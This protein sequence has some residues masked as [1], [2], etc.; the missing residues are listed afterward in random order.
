MP[1]TR[2]LTCAVVTVCLLGL[3]VAAGTASGAEKLRDKSTQPNIVFILADDLGWTDLGCYGNQFIETPVIDALAAAGARFTSAYTA[4]VCTPSRGMILS[5][6]SSARTGLYK[7]PFRGNERP[8]AKVVP[9]KPWGDRPVNA[10]PIAALLSSAG[11]SSRLVG[12]VHVPPAFTEGF[13]GKASLEEATVA[14]GTTFMGKLQVFAKDN[15]EKNVGPITLQAIEFIASN[16]DRPFFCYVGHH[17]PHIPLEARALLKKKYETKWKNHGG[18]IHPHYAAM[19][20]ALDQSV[21]FVLE[22][23]DRLG[24]SDNT[25]VVF[26]SDNGGVKR[27]FDDGK[28]AQITDL[29]PLRGEKG[30]LYEGGIRVP[31]IVRWPGSIR[32]GLVIDTPVISTDF[33]PTL[34]EAAGASLPPEQ[35]VDGVS[36]VPLLKESGHLKRRRLFLYFPDYHHDFP[37][38]VM[39]DGNLKLIKSS[40][41][42]RL[43]IYDLTGD[44]EERRDLAMAMPLL[45]TT[46][47]RK[48]LDEWCTRLGAHRATPNPDFDPRR[49]HML[50]PEA[51]AIRQRYLP[52]PWPPVGNDA[53]A[54]VHPREYEHALKNPLKGFRSRQRV[55]AH[56]YATLCR[57][58]LKWSDLERNEADGIERIMAICNREWRDVEKHNIKVIPRVYLHWSGNR[59]YWPDDMDKDDYSSKQFRERVRRLISRLGQCW[60]NDPRVAWVQMGLIGKWGEHHSPAITP[61]MQKLLGDAFTAAFKHKMVTIRHPWDFKEYRFGIYWDSWAHIQQM[62]SHGRGIEA[63]GIRWQTRPI[64]GECAYNW[65]QHSVQP[66]DDPDDTLRDPK[67]RGFLI[68]TIR[69]LHGN[70]LGWVSEYD[71]TDRHVHAGAEAVQKT[72]GYR[73]VIE[74]VRYPTTVEPQR[75]FHVSFS[76]RNTGSSPIYDNWPVEISLLDPSDRRVVWKSRFENLNIRTWLPGDDWDATRQAYRDA[77]RLYDTRGRLTLPPN[78]KRGK[79]VLALAILDPAGMLPSARF[80]IE[81]YF[82]GGRHPIGYIGVGIPLEDY[83]LDSKQFDDP[84][85]DHSLHYVLE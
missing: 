64:G 6:Q 63:L 1:S 66:G 39:R 79:Y 25:I 45:V 10:K 85:D 59:K 56:E 67:H 40:E 76:V 24:L 82:R 38:M 27:C 58:Y 70:N 31:L 61:E 8:W 75:A 62:D 5:G 48:T 50:A 33:L 78:I 15:P 47:L 57:V 69:Q 16:R 73:F 42:N 26:F 52:V 29:S 12:K 83:Q 46:D 74:E 84:A 3:L 4:P 54:V 28:G 43:R 65:G 19:C 36:L 2:P 18:R 35:V 68:D 60:D 41:D 72:F 32:S 22:A 14:L 55:G 23:L 44:I 20:E 80:A 7:V 53:I 13:D 17:A 77:P 34:I 21:G 30:S 51:A 37:A 11:Y 9:P 81:N 49:Q 71:A